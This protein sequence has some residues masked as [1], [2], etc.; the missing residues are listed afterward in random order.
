[1]I[2]PEQAS[3]IDSAESKKR[4]Y[5]SKFALK[6]IEEMRILKAGGVLG[7]ENAEWRNVSE[8][9]LTESVGADVLAEFLGADRT[10]TVK[11]AL[12]HDWFKRREVEAMKKFG[13]GTGHKTTSE[14]DEKL[15]REYVVDEE[16][17]RIARS[18]IPARIDPEYL[19]SRPIEEKIMHLIDIF[20]SNS[21]FVSIEKRY[22]LLEKKPLNIEFSESFKGQFGKALFEVQKEIAHAEQEDF[23]KAI[24][25]ERGSLVEFIKMKVQ[26][27]IDQEEDT[28]PKV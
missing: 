5:F 7:R 3:K 12:I 22:E 14:E 21:D 8:H 4:K 9:C 2:H 19:H 13:A 25:I 11:A 27:R 10:K 23:E 1:M 17:I 16:V 18:N 28:P 26:E 15:L 20:T 24:G 6:H